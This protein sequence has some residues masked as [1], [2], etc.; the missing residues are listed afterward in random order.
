[1]GIHI[2]YVDVWNNDGYS[3]WMNLSDA[4]AYKFKYEPEDQPY[5]NWNANDKPLMQDILHH[6]DSLGCST[7]T[8][9]GLRK[10]Y[11]YGLLSDDCPENPPIY[12]EDPLGNITLGQLKLTPLN[13]KEGLSHQIDTINKSRQNGAIIKYDAS[14][15][16]TLKVISKD[17][18]LKYF[19]QD[20]PND[21]DEELVKNYK[22][23][24]NETA[25]NF[26]KSFTI[27]KKIPKQPRV[28][29]AWL[30]LSDVHPCKKLYSLYVF[31][32]NHCSVYDLLEAC[33]TIFNSTQ[34][35]KLHQNGLDK[36]ESSSQ[37]VILVNLES[38]NLGRGFGNKVFL[39]DKFIS[40]VRWEKDSWYD[41]PLLCAHKRDLTDINS[42]MKRKLANSVYQIDDELFNSSDDDDNDRNYGGNFTLWPDEVEATPKI[43]NSSHSYIYSPKVPKHPKSPFGKIILGDSK[44]GTNNWGT[45]DNNTR[46]FF[47][48]Q[49]LQPCLPIDTSWL[50]VGH[51]DEILSVIRDNDQKCRLV[52]AS[53]ELMIDLLNK[54]KQV[55]SYS[56]SFFKG[57]FV[58]QEY[59]ERQLSYFLEEYKINFNRK[60]QREKLSP[61]KEILKKC[62]NISSDEKIIQI[63]VF[64]E[65][66]V[67]N[68]DYSTKSFSTRAETINLV[69]IQIIND[70]LLIPCP[71]GPRLLVNDCKNILSDY[72]DN[73]NI[74][75]PKGF[76]L[77][78]PK[79]V[80]LQALALCFCSLN[81]SEKQ[82]KIIDKVKSPKTNDDSLKKI[83][84][85]LVHKRN[86]MITTLTQ[87]SENQELKFKEDYI[88]EQWTRVWIPN[89]R[90]D[91]FE[92]YLK[93]ALKP[94]GKPVHF[95]NTLP[96]HI[97][98]GEIHCA[99]NAL[100]QCPTEW[101]LS[102]Y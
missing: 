5:E 52:Y 39:Q 72:F 77:W 81:N 42:A 4:S 43:D 15:Y 11:L 30:M 16:I 62:L 2:I 55:N 68:V 49:K 69:N 86:E 87:A 10:V 48:S 89:E 31:E 91:F 38:E 60:I 12:I 36:L 9:S 92:E 78:V 25:L 57:S 67:E 6:H 96:Y 17:Q 28:K 54:L 74:E 23:L 98:G 84:S 51:V 46:E 14:L 102:N 37:N 40:G 33:Y 32:Q 99:T 26:Q 65:S 90:V 88:F 66:K 58:Y 8:L 80:S 35:Y 29:G 79:G 82:Q 53:T 13:W 73:V 3:Q 100:R 95:V 71:L 24:I 85:E 59:K 1:M 27:T 45:V 64:F 20:A 22:K 18:A 21:S 19:W 70:H 34:A 63:P 83:C 76:W 56:L 61:T 47:F 7:D 44:H 93:L 94:L 75:I 101:N 41:S 50:R 97:E